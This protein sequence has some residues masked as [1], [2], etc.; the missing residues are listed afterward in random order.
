MQ[1]IASTSLFYAARLGDLELV[2]GVAKNRK[3]KERLRDR[4][5]EQ[6]CQGGVHHLRIEIFSKEEFII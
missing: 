2:Q 4:G 1:T 3:G 5:E 6:S